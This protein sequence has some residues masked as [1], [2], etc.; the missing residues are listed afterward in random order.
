MDSNGESVD[1]GGDWE[2]CGQ[3]CAGGGELADSS[4][5]AAE[6]GGLPGRRQTFSGRRF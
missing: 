4:G 3:R 6:S 2:V 5:K 1:S